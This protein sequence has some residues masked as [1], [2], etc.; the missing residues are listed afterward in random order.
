M[1]VLTRNACKSSLGSSNWKFAKIFMSYH[2]KRELSFG[3]SLES[4]K[5]KTA[6]GVSEFNKLVM[7]STVF[8]DKTLLT[9]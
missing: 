4:H 1:K 2:P 8:V 7:G 6:I 5:A 3:N 9:K